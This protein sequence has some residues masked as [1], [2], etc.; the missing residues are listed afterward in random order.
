MSAPRSSGSWPTATSV[1]D[2]GRRT[3]AAYERFAAFY[4]EVMD[5]P[6]PRAARVFDAIARYHPEAGSLLELGCGTGSI[7]A[8]LDGISSRVG[9][10]RSPEMLAVARRKVPDVALVEGDLS[11]FSLDRTFDVIICVFDTLNHLL[12][13]EAW[14]ATFDAVAAHLADD[15]LFVFDVNTIG[16]LRRLGEDPPAVYDFERGVAVVDVA[17]AHDGEQTGLSQWDIRIFEE[18]GGCRY[19]L[20]RERI[21]ELGVDLARV[22]AAVAERFELLELTDEGGEPASDESV[23]AHVVARR[24]VQRQAGRAAPFDASLLGA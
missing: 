21:D 3:V 18:Q 7:L 12:T 1:P 5:D 17:F 11:S 15:G 2:W 13:F 24:R 14:L 8:R 6:G 10:D 9:L 23:K 4:D 22:G 19:R 20:H 16:E